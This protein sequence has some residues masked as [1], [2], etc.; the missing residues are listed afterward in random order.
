VTGK[1][2]D[3]VDGTRR[4]GDPP[5]LVAEPGRAHSALGWRPR[6]SGTDEI[7]GTAWVLAPEAIW[8]IE[9]DEGPVLNG[10]LRHVSMLPEGLQERIIGLTDIQ[11]QSC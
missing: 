11:S 4:P 5:L 2:I 8:M 6:M 1:T 9:C 3:I 7:V 10:D